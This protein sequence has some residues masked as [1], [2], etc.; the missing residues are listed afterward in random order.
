VPCRLSFG[1][2]A[3]GFQFS[4]GGALRRP[5]FFII[6]APKCGTT[7]LSVWLSEHPKIFMSPIKEPHFFNTDDRQAVTTLDQYEALFRDATEEHI[8]V[9][10]ASVWYLSSAEAVPAIVRYQP[11]AKFIVMVRNP[12]EMAPAMHGEMLRAGLE[13]EQRFSRAWNLQDERRQGRRVPPAYCWA[14]RRFLYGDVCSLGMQL[15]RLFM[16]VSPNRV[17]T[18][19]LDEIRADSRREYLQVLQ[20]LGVPDDGR[21]HF[22]LYNPA[23]A[24]RYP[25]LQRVVYP[26]LEL[27]DRLGMRSCLGVWASVEKLM[28]IEKPREPLT[29]E[30]RSVLKEYFSEDVQLSGQLLGKD[31][32]RWLAIER[33]MAITW[34]PDPSFTSAEHAFAG[35]RELIAF[36]IPPRRDIGG[37]DWVDGICGERH[38][39]GG[40]V[41]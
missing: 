3:I 9:G 32:R 19:Y 5:N 26:A 35:E 36:D 23:T 40:C 24:F 2:I 29:H 39:D 15:Q 21:V 25:S 16:T 31:L 8:A 37:G 4:G 14:R 1:L 41:G 10:E 17:L 38:G 18:V 13:Y 22:P 34:T 33:Q 20:F 27:K 7:S 11:E 12:I 28:R 30:M 6:G